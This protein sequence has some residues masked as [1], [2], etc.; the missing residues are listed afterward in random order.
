MNIFE[1]INKLAKKVDDLEK[2]T[3]NIKKIDNQFLFALEAIRI[4]ILS[5][6]LKREAEELFELTRSG[7]AF[8]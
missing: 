3:E 7:K 8:E 5:K 4:D 1:R 2:R 6:K